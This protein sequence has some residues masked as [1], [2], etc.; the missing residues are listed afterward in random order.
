[1]VLDVPGKDLQFITPVMS[2][3]PRD[4]ELDMILEYS[5]QSPGHP[6]LICTTH[7]NHDDD[8]SNLYHYSVIMHSAC[9]PARIVRGRGA[10]LLP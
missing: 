3:K 2:K 8:D 1:M 10:S 7:K 4:V 5:E 9:K 6:I